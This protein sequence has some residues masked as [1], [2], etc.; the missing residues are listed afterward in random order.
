MMGDWSDEEGRQGTS[1]DLRSGGTE[2]RRR[3]GSGSGS[4]RE[5]PE[6]RAGVVDGVY[7]DFETT[8]CGR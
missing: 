2:E 1:K 3:S 4:G 6:R 5:M 8:V 7:D